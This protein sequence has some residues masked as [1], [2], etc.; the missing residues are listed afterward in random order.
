MDNEAKKTP[1]TVDLT[2]LTFVGG[3]FDGFDE[4]I[5]SDEELPRCVALPMDG[6]AEQI[7]GIKFKHSKLPRVAIYTLH[8]GEGSAYYRF[9]CSRNTEMTRFRVDG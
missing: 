8:D 4:M 5:A 6:N 9:H 1:D 2:V 3:P 7:F